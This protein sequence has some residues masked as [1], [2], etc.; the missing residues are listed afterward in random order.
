MRR[1]NIYNRRCELNLIK[2]VTISNSDTGDLFQGGE[3]KS[4]R[5]FLPNDVENVVDGIIIKN[6]AGKVYLIVDP[7]RID[8]FPNYKIWPVSVNGQPIYQGIRLHMKV[9]D[10]VKVFPADRLIKIT[11]TYS[12]GF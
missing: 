6:I 11:I 10:V 12:L 8:K 4:V 1:S 5:Y 3:K 9:N 7:D 2:I